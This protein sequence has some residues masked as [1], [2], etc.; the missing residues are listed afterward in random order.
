MLGS[1]VS[2][3][4]EEKLHHT[5]VSAAG[6]SQ[7]AGVCRP[8]S[9]GAVL[10]PPTCVISLLYSEGAA[11]PAE[12]TTRKLNLA[13]WFGLRLVVVV[14]LAYSKNGPKISVA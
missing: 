9:F 11:L 8:L 14:H 12:Y 10:G 6:I 1:I 7:R 3:A 4:V 2:R 5:A 13:S